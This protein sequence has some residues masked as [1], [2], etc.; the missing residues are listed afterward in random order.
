MWTVE[1]EAG[2]VYLLG[3]IHLLPPETEWQTA[4]IKAAIAASSVFVFEAPI[5]DANATMAPV[6]SSAMV[7]SKAGVR[8]AN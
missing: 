8:C 1:H 2:R 5:S 7:G 4:E 6:L 3:S